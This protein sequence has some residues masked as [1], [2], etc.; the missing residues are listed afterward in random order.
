MLFL[1]SSYMFAQQNIPIAEKI[2]Y[3]VDIRDAKNPDGSNIYSNIEETQRIFYIE[4]LIKAVESGALKAYSD[5]E[6]F[7]ELT[8][9]E[10]GNILVIHDTAYMNNPENPSEEIMVAVEEEIG[11]DEITALNFMEEWTFDKNTMKLNKRIIAV[12]PLLEMLVDSE[13]GGEIVGH[14]ILFWVKL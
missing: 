11:M 8:Q 12:A 7:Q 6:L 4:N 13:D 10:I 14:K 5:E 2:I 1:Y 3:K 9:N